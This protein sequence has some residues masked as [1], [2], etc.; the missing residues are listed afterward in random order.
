[1]E[2]QKERLNEGISFREFSLWHAQK[3]RRTLRCTKPNPNSEKHTDSK[4]EDVGPMA[5]S[6][7][8]RE[9]FTDNGLEGFSRI[10]DAPP[11]EEPEQVAPTIDL[12]KITEGTIQA[13]TGLQS[14]STKILMEYFG[15]YSLNS[16]V[17][18]TKGRTGVVGKR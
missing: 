17:T 13:L 6:D 4:E 7:K 15:E 10:A 9:C 11:H 2:L 16:N 18:H 12:A 14:P 1:M 8:A 3:D 5:L